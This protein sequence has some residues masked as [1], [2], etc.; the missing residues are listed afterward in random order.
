MP[1]TGRSVAVSSSVHR[2][3]VVL[4]GSGWWS[5]HGQ[6]HGGSSRSITLL[7]IDHN[8][9][10]AG[11]ATVSTDSR[12]TPPTSARAPASRRPRGILGEEGPSALSARRL[13]AGGRHL[14]DGR[15]H[16]LRRDAG[17]G[18]TRSWPR[19]SAGSSTHVDAVGTTDDP[20]ADLRR[21]AGGVPRQRAGEPAPL[22]RHVRGRISLGGFHG[23]TTTTSEVGARRP[24]TRS[25]PASSGRWRP[26]RCAAGDPRGR[27][28][29][30]SGAPCTAT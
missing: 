20:L 9:V 3:E 17:A 24:S 28:R 6:G 5:V 15:L 14:D 30:S 8:A 23:C 19:A 10:M 2:G 25:S 27:R 21:M 22:R 13:A 12:R 7:S 26:A 11:M 18:A 29:R 16:A 1:V 4:R